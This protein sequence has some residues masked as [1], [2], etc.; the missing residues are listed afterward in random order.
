MNAANFS[1]K[2]LNDARFAIKNR[3]QYKIKCTRCTGGTLVELECMMC[4]EWKGLE[5]FA[6]SQRTKPDSAVSEYKIL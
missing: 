1:S 6:K 5:E 2:Q 4:N 3:A